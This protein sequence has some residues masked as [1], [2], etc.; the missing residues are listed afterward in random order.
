LSESRVAVSMA[1]NVSTSAV[2]SSSK[3]FPVL[4][5]WLS[6]HLD[7]PQGDRKELHRNPNEPPHLPL[8]RPRAL[9]LPLP[10]T[11]AGASSKQSTS[12]QEH[13]AFLNLPPE[14]RLRIYEAMFG[15]R[16]IHLFFDFAST[17][18]PKLGRKSRRAKS[19]KKGP[20]QWHFSHRVCED[21]P[22]YLEA[23]WIFDRCYQDR[24]GEKLAALNM[25]AT[26]RKV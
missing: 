19:K 24:E 3:T 26:C 13:S 17:A 12:L 16:K 11:P 14:I 22:P 1:F 6:R 10:A 8:C 4:R 23:A 20:E 9:T 18:T 25:L 21:E 15:N 7:A 5:K 2:S